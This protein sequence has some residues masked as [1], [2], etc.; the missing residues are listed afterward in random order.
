MR[1]PSTATA[2][3]RGSESGEMLD[4]APGLAVNWQQRWE[5]TARPDLCKAAWEGGGWLQTDRE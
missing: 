3:G 2:A 1:S 4:K 5:V